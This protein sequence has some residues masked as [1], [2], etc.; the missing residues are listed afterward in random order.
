MKQKVLAKS[1]AGTVLT[2]DFQIAGK[3]LAVDVSR[4]KPEVRAHAEVHGW[5]QRF[6]DLESGDKTGSLK[7]AACKE[8]AEHLT[9]GG[10]WD[11]PREVDTTAIV[12]E[13]VHRMNPKKYPVEMLQKAAEKKPEQVADWRANAEVKS[14]IAKIRSERA[15]AAAKEAEKEDLK[16]EL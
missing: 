11:M 13:A 3:K 6:G 14:M 12:I 1:M 10:G 8:L 5:L 2:L 15:A 9:A 4:F 7:F 16:I